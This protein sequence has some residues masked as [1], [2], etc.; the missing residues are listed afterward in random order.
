ML[1]REMNS[2]MQKRISA[3]HAW[4]VLTLPS[5]SS[6][7]VRKCTLAQLHGSCGVFVCCPADC[8][9]QRLCNHREQRHGVKQRWVVTRENAR[10]KGVHT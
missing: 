4:L 1:C 9:R 6:A 2:M 8:V 3:D 10:V 7:S 5:Q